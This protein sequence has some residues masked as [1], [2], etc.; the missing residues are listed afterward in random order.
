MSISK[1]RAVK[2]KIGK[3]AAFETEQLE[4][5]LASSE[6]NEALEG[7]KFHIDEV[8]VEIEC[9]DCG[10]RYI[11]DRFNDMNFAHQIAHAPALY[12]PPKCPCCK[13]EDVTIIAGREMEL[14][15]I[16]GE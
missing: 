12:T 3:M 1:V 14:T 4:F 10:K 6:K 7:I 9:K 11:D 13:S 5:A 8:P 2:L 16:E 15:S